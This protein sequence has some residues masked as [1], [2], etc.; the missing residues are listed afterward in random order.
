MM[1]V[2]NGIAIDSLGKLRSTALRKQLGC[3]DEFTFSPGFVT[4]KGAAHQELHV[5]SPDA[6]QVKKGKGS[7]ILHLPLSVEGLT[8]RVANLRNQVQAQLD[9]P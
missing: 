3:D 6:Y 9:G 7:Y 1:S 4:T 8:L 2:S 5:D